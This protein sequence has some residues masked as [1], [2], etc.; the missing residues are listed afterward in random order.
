MISF[1]VIGRNFITDWFLDA[2]A[3]ADELFF[4][5]VYSRSTENAAEYANR[6]G[7]ER[8]Y[9]SIDEMCEDKSLDMVYI[10]SPNL[11]HEE[12]AVRL[13]N[14]GKH[15]FCEKP[16]ALSHGG[17]MNMLNAAE[18]NGCIFMEGMVPLHMPAFGKIRELISKIGKIRHASFVFC[19]YSSRY[20]KYKRGEKINTFDPTLGNGA[21]MDLGIYCVSTMAALFGYPESVCGSVN[22]LP[23]SIDGCGTVI[24]AYD[25]MN[26]E[27]SFSKV[28]DSAVSSE[29][30]GENG[31]ILIDKISRPKKITLIPRGRQPELYDMTPEHH[32]MYYEI[33]DFIS[34]ING[35][36][37]T[38][39]NEISKL[40]LRF[41]DEVR[42]KT[43]IDFK[44]H[45]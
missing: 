33:S 17:L 38:Y 41:A 35:E 15:V 24:A 29:I 9:K 12:Q 23:E 6:K 20:D 19:Q 21:F 31:C 10:A 34:Q 3:E 44:V 30:Q 22:F 2:A 36:K 45:K 28:S 25:G 1:A 16:A 13:L 14:A 42:K 40:S 7:A 39:Y 18:E 32:E 26:A 37:N 4:K 11:F 8:I 43:G 27:I 5:G